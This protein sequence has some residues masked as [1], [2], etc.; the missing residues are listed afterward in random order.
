MVGESSI[1]GSPVIRPLV[2]GH[3]GAAGHEVENTR[4]AFLKGLALGADGVECDVRATSDGKLVIFHDESLLRL[5]GLPERLNRLTLA[6]LQKRVRLGE[7]GEPILTLEELCSMPEV[8]NAWL[9]I[10]LKE[11]RLEAEAIRIVQKTRDAQNT[12]LGSFRPETVRALTA[13]NFPLP[14]LLSETFAMP[15]A[16]V[17]IAGLRHEALDPAKVTGLHRQQLQV[18]SWTVNETDDIQ[19]MISCRVDGLIT[20]YPDRAIRELNRLLPLSD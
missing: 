8:Q 12:V 5:A 6:D 20:D 10:E 18:W 13:V 16:G 17:Q 15:P 11:P 7:S 9:F 4:V 14:L 1:P 19:R 2:I 3:R